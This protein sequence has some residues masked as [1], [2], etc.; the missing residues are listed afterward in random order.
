MRPEAVVG[1][2]GIEVIDLGRSS[3]TSGDLDPVIAMTAFKH[4][5]VR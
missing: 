2:Y 4:M 5:R 3:S 1:A